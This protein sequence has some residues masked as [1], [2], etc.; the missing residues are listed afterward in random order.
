[1]VQS[2]LGSAQPTQATTQSA[3]P[4]TPTP[5]TLEV[6]EL[7]ELSLA[8]SGASDVPPDD[9]AFAFVAMVGIEVVDVPKVLEEEMVDYEATPERAKVIVVYLFAKYYVVGGDSTVV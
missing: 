7:A 8:V 2:T 1:M 4:T 3:D 5:A 9:F 6:P